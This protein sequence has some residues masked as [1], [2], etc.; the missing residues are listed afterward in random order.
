VAKA[1][2]MPKF[3]MT[4]EVGVIARWLKQ[5][6]DAV[7]KGDPIAEVET[8]KVNMEVEAPADGFLGGIR[9]EEGDTVPVTEI[10][11]Y[12]L[13]EGEKALTAPPR[14]A[15]PSTPAAAPP[16]PPATAAG[17]VIIASPIAQRLAAAE[18]INLTAVTGSGPNGKVTRQDV[19]L[20][21]RE[22]AVQPAAA[23]PSDGKVRATP[24]AR[25]IARENGLNL[26]TVPGS[27]PR[28][29]IQAADATEAIQ[30][31]PIPAPKPAPASGG[32]PVIVPLEGMRRTI[33]E[34]LQ[35]SYQQAPHIMFTAQVEMSA[36]IKA[37]TAINARL[38]E[39]Q[40]TISITAFVIKAVA[41]ALRQHPTVNS[42]FYNDQ[43]LVMPE[44]NVGMA[45]ALETGLI[46]PVIPQAD[47]KGLAQIG[48]EVHDLTARARAGQ[49][50]P[51]DVADG[52][53]TVSNLGMFGIDHFTAIINPPQVA[54][55]AV[56]R[57]DKR[58]VPDENDQ[59]VL[60]PLMTM[61]LSVDHRV[62]DGAV[63]AR[64]MQSL[65][66]A[67]ENPVSMLL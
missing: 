27:G 25:R 63:A 16:V 24:A 53:F 65:R 8:D 12:V 67:L 20:Y 28:R 26:A 3:S 29:R 66:E 51:Q 33:A 62:V 35:A 44:V 47:R 64:F 40:P 34:R 42:L 2:I 11:A 6:G 54:I 18:G 59:P 39:D 7:E 21:L 1:V 19:E 22:Q 9:Y 32:E 13:A 15:A 46:V 30:A 57:I 61:T 14:P 41:W 45:V 31:A 56:A 4:Q 23:A 37:R 5:A 48:A 43:I 10:I 60:K 58:F 17:G 38:P 52:T 50:R 49:L 36:V 55:L